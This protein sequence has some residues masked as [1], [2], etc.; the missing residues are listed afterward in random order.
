MKERFE[1]GFCE[2]RKHTVRCERLA[3]PKEKGS[4]KRSDENSR[5][6][7]GRQSSCVFQPC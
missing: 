5:D 2:K 1:I 6:E 4:K 3:G 7:I